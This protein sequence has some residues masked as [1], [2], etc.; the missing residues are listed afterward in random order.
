MNMVVVTTRQVGGIGAAVNSRAVS[1]PGGLVGT[2]YE[3][4]PDQVVHAVGILVGDEP[5]GEV[6]AAGDVVGIVW[7]KEDVAGF[8]AR[9]VTVGVLRVGVPACGAVA[10]GSGGGE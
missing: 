5:A 4:L 3:S 2:P 1:G 8:T 9:V 7:V 10:D 6:P